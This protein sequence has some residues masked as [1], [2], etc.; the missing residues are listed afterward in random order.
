MSLHRK[1][2][3]NTT[4]VMKKEQPMSDVNGPPDV[5]PFRPTATT[6]V[7]NGKGPRFARTFQV[8]GTEVTVRLDR[9]SLELVI[10]AW[11]KVTI[12]FQRKRLELVVEES[13][14]D[15]A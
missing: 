7:L 15:A 1:E 3:H 13:G 11:T 9:N 4:N 5:L 12:R 14:K 10:L 2:A 8:G 6:G